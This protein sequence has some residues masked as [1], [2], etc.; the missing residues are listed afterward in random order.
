MR[1]S[2][3]TAESSDGAPWPTSIHR[4][5]PPGWTLGSDR[6]KPYPTRVCEPHGPGECA[7][8]GVQATERGIELGEHPRGQRCKGRGATTQRR[9]RRRQRAQRV[10]TLPAALTE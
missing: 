7:R 3:S 5:T 4:A 2:S 8:C 10:V 1:T 9:E 6:C